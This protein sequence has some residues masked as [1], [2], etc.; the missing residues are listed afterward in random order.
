MDAQVAEATMNVMRFSDPMGPSIVSMTAGNAELVRKVLKDGRCNV[1]S[2]GN[3]PLH[4][5]VQI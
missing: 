1:N 2:T 3:T 5:G 4:I